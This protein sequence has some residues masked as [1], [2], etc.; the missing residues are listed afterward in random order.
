MA[1]DCSEQVTP[2]Q[3]R[4]HGACIL[5]GHIL[6]NERFYGSAIVKALQG[7]FKHSKHA[8]FDGVN[9]ARKLKI[10]CR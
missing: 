10:R 8:V 9:V 3:P 7:L 2:S 5:S 6:V 4:L 1:S